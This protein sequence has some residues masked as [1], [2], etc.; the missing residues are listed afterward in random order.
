MHLI[1]PLSFGLASDPASAA[2]SGLARE[3]PL[4]AP[5]ALHPSGSEANALRRHS[6][7]RP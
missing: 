7:N 6:V 3:R 2:L 4:P 1:F 5:S